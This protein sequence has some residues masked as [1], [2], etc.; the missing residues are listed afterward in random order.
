VSQGSKPGT[1][2]LGRIAWNQLSKD[3]SNKGRLPAS[4]ATTAAAAITPVTAS[5][6]ASASATT[7]TA[8]ATL[9][10]WTSF[11]DVQCAAAELRSI[12]SSDC[13]FSVFVIRHFHETEAARPTGIAIRHDGDPID[14]PILLKHL[15]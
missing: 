11:I 3:A 6:A 15:A 4:A 10:L 2:P 1:L 12:Q 13:L 9:C 7:T 14:L 8:A 5:S